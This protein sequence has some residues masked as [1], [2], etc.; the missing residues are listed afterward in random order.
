MQK[1]IE[2][3]EK[4]GTVIRRKVQTINS[5]PSMTKQSFKNECDINN[6]LKK[7]AKTGLINHVN[8]YEGN[9][10]VATSLDFKQAMDLVTSAQQMFDDLPSSVRDRFQNDPAQFLDFVQNPDNAQEMV[11]MGLA[12]ASAVAEKEYDESIQNAAREA[13]TPVPADT[14]QTKPTD[15]K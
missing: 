8:Q 9:Y 4:D 2:I 10:D 14:D 7:H 6:I 1:T 5:D 13:G 12:T 11:K 15:K 3:T